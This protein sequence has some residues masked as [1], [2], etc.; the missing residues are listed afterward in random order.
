TAQVLNQ[1]ENLRP[2]II[3][4]LQASESYEL[5]MHI[6]LHDEEWNL[7]WETL[8]AAEQQYRS[9]IYQPKL[10]II[11]AEASRHVMPERALPIYIKYARHYIERRGRSNYQTTADLLKIVQE[12]YDQL[13][14]IETW[15]TLIADIRTEF[16][17][18]P[19]L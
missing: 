11:V 4:D 2:Q 13:N 12:L 6:Y 18:L 9:S 17:N 19:A 16:K 7:A 3:R 5:L 1:W 15:E 14:E 10:D 8:P